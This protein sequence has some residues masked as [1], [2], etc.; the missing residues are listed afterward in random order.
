MGWAIYIVFRMIILDYSPWYSSGLV[1][2]MVIKKGWNCPVVE[3]LIL[4][5]GYK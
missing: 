3:L 1:V 4:V 5:S 2:D